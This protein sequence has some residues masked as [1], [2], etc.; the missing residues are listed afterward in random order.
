MA[1]GGTRKAQLAALDKE[2]QNEQDEWVKA[3][4]PNPGQLF[5]MNDQEF[6]HHCHVE[7]MLVILKEKLGMS[8]EE[9]NLYYKRVVLREME[10]LRVIA[11]KL[12]S[13]A[14]RQSIVDGTGLFPPKPEI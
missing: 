11:A 7:T 8:D 3:K 14:L 13:A 10:G 6:Q 5:R 12:R 2:L 9:L 4:L 1:E